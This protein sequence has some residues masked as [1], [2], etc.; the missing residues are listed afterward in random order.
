MSGTGDSHSL[1]LRLFFPTYSQFNSSLLSVLSF[2][3]YL[4]L[5]IIYTT[6]RMEQ[7]FSKQ[8]TE[9]RARFLLQNQIKDVKL[10]TWE[11]KA[12]FHF[13]TLHK[14]YVHKAKATREQFVERVLVE[15]PGQ[16]RSDIEVC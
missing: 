7:R 15:M 6:H 1:P 5:Y 9:L 14:L 10:G 16:S 8:L 2:C 13:M 12:H 3:F 11:A 4:A